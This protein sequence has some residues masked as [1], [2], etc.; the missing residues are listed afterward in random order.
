MNK[1]KSVIYTIKNGDLW[2]VIM[3]C[4][5]EITI[6][7]GGKREECAKKLQKNWLYVSRQYKNNYAALFV[8]YRKRRKRETKDGNNNENKLHF[9]FIIIFRLI[10]RR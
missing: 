1:E 2:L 6:S 4:N 5:C 7:K 9:I 10:I 8:L 3:G